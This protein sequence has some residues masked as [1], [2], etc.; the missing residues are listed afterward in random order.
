MNSMRQKSHSRHDTRSS[1][2]DVHS[3]DQGAMTPRHVRQTPSFKI[4]PD[5]NIKRCVG[6]LPGIELHDVQ[7][8]VL[9]C[10]KS[11]S[12]VLGSREGESP[13]NVTESSWDPSSS[14]T[15]GMSSTTL[16]GEDEEAQLGGTMTPISPDDA[17][18]PADDDAERTADDLD[19][20]RRGHR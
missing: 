1:G 11:K 8:D 5:D 20:P 14:A 15:G 6:N 10:G 4:L 7:N 17:S 13:R 16:D 2:T 18:C 3:E 9:N 19:V 12:N